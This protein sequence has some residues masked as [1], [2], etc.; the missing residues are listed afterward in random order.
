MTVTKQKTQIIKI[1]IQKNKQIRNN[2]IQIDNCMY[3]TIDN[4]VCTGILCAV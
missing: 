1:R 4:F 2:N 3:I